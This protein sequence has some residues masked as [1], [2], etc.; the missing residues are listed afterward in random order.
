MI[1]IRPA[2]SSVP[3]ATSWKLSGRARFWLFA[4][5]ILL[6]GGFWPR[7]VAEPVVCPAELLPDRCAEWRRRWPNG[8]FQT[9]HQFPIAVWL[10]DPRNAGRYKQIGV[11]LYVGLWKGPTERQLAELRHHQMPVI[12]Q[13]NAYAL[14]HLDEKLIVG[15]LQQDEP[16]NA[17]PLPGGKGYGPPVAPEQVIQRYEEIRRRDPTRPVL[18]NLGQA[19]AWDGWHGRGIRTHHPEDYL[20]YVKGG[21]IVSFD[22][23]P[24]VHSNPA[25]AGRL[26]YV[27][28]GVQ[29]LR[30]WAGH[31]QLIW[32]CIETTR[33]RNL[34]LKPT[35]QQVKAE[36][37]MSLIFGSQGIIYFCH[38]F[39]P[40]FIEA[41]LL[42]DAEMVDAI[43]KLN[44]QI[45]QLAPVLWS[46]ERRDLL[47]ISV[48]PA[49]VDAEMTRLLGPIPIAWTARVYQNKLYIFSVRMEPTEAKAQFRLTRPA[50]IS[51]LQVLGENRSLPIRQGVFQD[52]FGPYEVH[53]YEMVL[54]ED[55]SKTLL[56]LEQAKSASFARGTEKGFSFRESAESRSQAGQMGEG[57]K[58]EFYPEMTFSPVLEGWIPREKWTNDQYALVRHLQADLQH[59]WQNLAPQWAKLLKP[60]KVRELSRWARPQML[61]YRRVPPL[62]KTLLEPRALSAEG[63]QLLLEGTVDTLPTHHR[64]VTRWL[65]VYLFYDLSERKIRRIVFTI[66]GQ[67]EE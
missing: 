43:A 27:P 32:N 15:W 24:V 9:C 42:A 30:Q 53:L 59:S 52:H 5:G 67:L 47:E 7:G 54:P 36:V 25:V 41:A 51:R 48:Q 40:N 28:R 37:W 21:D 22:I 65:K 64:L 31:D 49:E 57:T 45:H 29:R 58:V 4:L 56:P 55:L 62:E 18:L 61:L 20:L 13:Q 38:Q 34:Q 14:A 11:N 10:Q 3:P 19:V 63:N 39:K 66:R 2:D 23:Y 17:Q 8:P 26:W 1:R 50:G 16:D 44:Q 35:P 12:C 46:P 60:E 33:I 6:G